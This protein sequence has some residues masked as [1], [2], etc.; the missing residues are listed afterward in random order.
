ME[1]GFAPDVLADILTRLPPNTRRRVRLVC[2]HWRHLIDTHTA[3]D[4]QSRAKTLVV[5]RETAYIFTPVR[6]LPSI[7]SRPGSWGLA[8]VHGRLPSIRISVK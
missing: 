6:P 7:L 8:E 1:K 3:T 2:R 4:L 5:T